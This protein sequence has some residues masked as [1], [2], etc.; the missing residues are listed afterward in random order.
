MLQFYLKI[1]KDKKT[2]KYKKSPKEMIKTRKKKD[3]VN[4]KHYLKIIGKLESNKGVNWKRYFA[5]L[6]R[7]VFAV[8]CSRIV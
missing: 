3:G 5:F 1:F 4:I 2:A 7:V 6:E 8:Y